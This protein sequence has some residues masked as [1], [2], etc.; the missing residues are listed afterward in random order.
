[1]HVALDYIN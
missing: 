1:M